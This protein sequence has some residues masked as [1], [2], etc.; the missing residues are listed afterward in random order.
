[1]GGDGRVG[2]QTGGEEKGAKTD[3]EGGGKKRRKGTMQ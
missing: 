2:A 1:M 3:G